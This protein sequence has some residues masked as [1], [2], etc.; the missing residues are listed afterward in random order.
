MSASP[1][2]GA[3]SLDKFSFTTVSPDGTRLACVLERKPTL[4]KHSGTCVLVAHGLGQV[5]S[6]AG[7]FE[8][9]NDPAGQVKPGN[10][11]AC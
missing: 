7:R 4:T 6:A 3:S 9:A 11:R 10:S 2:G 1:P 5:G 8:P